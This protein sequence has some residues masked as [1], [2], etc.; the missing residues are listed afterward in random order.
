LLC[1]VILSFPNPVQS[2]N[3]I[4]INTLC[5]GGL[6]YVIFFFQILVIDVMRV[7]LNV[8]VK[9]FVGSN[10]IVVA[11]TYR[12]FSSSTHFKY[13]CLWSLYIF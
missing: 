1:D 10:V 13:C 5:S 9:T 4:F 3:V 6:G 8:E 7:I 2:E 11:F 12:C